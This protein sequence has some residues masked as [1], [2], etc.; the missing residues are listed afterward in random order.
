MYRDARCL[1][2]KARFAVVIPIRKDETAQRRLRAQFGQCIQ[3][4][5]FST[6][7]SHSENVTEGNDEYPSAGAANTNPDESILPFD[8]KDRSIM[9][10]GIS[11]I[12]HA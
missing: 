11:D 12:G 6:I 8:G 10:V 7:R 3:H 4:H 2:L 9:K 5:A 1:D